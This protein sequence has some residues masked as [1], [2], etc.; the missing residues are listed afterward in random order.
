MEQIKLILSQR[1]GN[2]PRTPLVKVALADIIHRRWGIEVP[3]SAIECRAGV[4]FL[5]VKPVLKSEIKLHQ[6]EILDE[7]QKFFPVP[8]TKN[9]V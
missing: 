2:L 7:L 1:R 6:Q 5:Q 4:I 8:A 9:F 3:A